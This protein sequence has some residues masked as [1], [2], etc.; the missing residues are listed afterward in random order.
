L[1]NL[2]ENNNATPES[3]AQ[4]LKNGRKVVIGTDTKGEGADHARP[5]LA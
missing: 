4:E 1:G 5:V 2:K 3:L